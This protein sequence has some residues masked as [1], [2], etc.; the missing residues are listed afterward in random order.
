MKSKDFTQL[1]LYPIFNKKL[2]LNALIME[3]NQLTFDFTNNFKGDSIDKT[4]SMMDIA[5]VKGIN[6]KFE[7]DPLVWFS[8]ASTTIDALKNIEEKFDKIL[9]WKE[10]KKEYEK[11][12]SNNNY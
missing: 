3:S 6:G 7:M 1:G 12:L 4:F 5:K 8:N 9:V 10:L 11:N 2:E